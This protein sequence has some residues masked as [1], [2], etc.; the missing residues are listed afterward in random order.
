MKTRIKLAN[1]S[2]REKKR[3]ILLKEFLDKNIFQKELLN[4]YGIEGV[5]KIVFKFDNN[6]IQTTLDS[7]SKII[8]CLNYINIKNI[9]KCEIEK[10]SGT[11]KGLK[12]G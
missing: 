12:N 4:L 8:F 11:I 1:K 2:L 10:I 5:S 9:K 3:Y 7:L 6:I